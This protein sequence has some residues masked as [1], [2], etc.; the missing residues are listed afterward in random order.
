MNISVLINAFFKSHSRCILIK[1][2]QSYTQLFWDQV[3]FYNEQVIAGVVYTLALIHHSA[4]P[5][6]YKPICDLL[7]I[8]GSEIY[9]ITKLRFFSHY[10]K[11]PFKGINRGWKD[12]GSILEKLIPK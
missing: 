7:D 8:S 5:M 9:R 3:N 11:Q 6:P 10:S 4:E 12:I 1:K 2:K